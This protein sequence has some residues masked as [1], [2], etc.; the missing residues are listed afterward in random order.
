VA[1]A[2]EETV[3]DGEGGPERLLL[4]LFVLVA[5][6]EFRVEADAD[7]EP[8][9][10]EMVDERRVRVLG[11]TEA[12]EVDEDDGDAEEEEVF[13]VGVEVRFERWS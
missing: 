10:A 2:E 1:G 3:D 9:A 6:D 7:A 13:M 11:R 4:L 5:R 12:L 8:V